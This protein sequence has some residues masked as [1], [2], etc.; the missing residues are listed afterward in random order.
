MDM[1]GATGPITLAGTLV[2]QNCE[3]LA[4]LV[5]H[6]LTG[7]G[8]AFMYGTCTTG[9]DMRRS[10]APMGSPEAALFQAGSVALANHYRIP[11]WT[12]GLRQTPK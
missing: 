6:Q 10:T 2:V 4:S 12:L 11:S 5:L 9:F 8:A 1:A 3:Q 7:K